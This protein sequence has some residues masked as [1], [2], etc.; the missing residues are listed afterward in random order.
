MCVSEL[1]AHILARKKLFPTSKSL[2]PMCIAAANPPMQDRTHNNPRNKI[3]C[4][5]LGVGKDG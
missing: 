4:R 1:N 2:P 3:Y 5:S